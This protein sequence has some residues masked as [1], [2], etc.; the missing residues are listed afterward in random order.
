M[1]MSSDPWQSRSSRNLASFCRVSRRTICTTSERLLITCPFR[2]C[3]WYSA[4]TGCRRMVSSFFTPYDVDQ[5][6]SYYCIL[7]AST[8][9]LIAQETCFQ[10]LTS[11]EMRI[12]P[13]YEGSGGDVQGTL[14]ACST[15]KSYAFRHTVCDD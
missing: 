14:G 10:T 4:T 12:P 5:S 11:L 13:Q 1:L 8:M 3:I 2:T 15:I 6:L 9:A 7:S